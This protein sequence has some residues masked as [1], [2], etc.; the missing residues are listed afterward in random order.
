[1]NVTCF[2]NVELELG[3]FNSWRL[4]KQRPQVEYGSVQRSPLG[5]SEVDASTCTFSIEVGK[6]VKQVVQAHLYRCVGYPVCWVQR[7]DGLH[8]YLEQN[9]QLLIKSPLHLS[10]FS[11]TKMAYQVN[12]LSV[13]HIV[14]ELIQDSNSVE[15]NVEVEQSQRVQIQDLVDDQ[16]V[17][18]LIDSP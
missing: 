8:E 17:L 11:T 10:S 13:H 9:K 14:S 4:N 18:V 3:K 1:M 16:R 6:D 5:Q 15:L 12:I 2:E 7:I